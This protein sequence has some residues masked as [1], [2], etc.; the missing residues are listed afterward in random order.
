MEVTM[1]FTCDQKLLSEAITSVSRAV[2]AK[3]TIPALGG[4]K[5]SVSGDTLTLTGYNLEIGI[6]TSLSVTSEGE[7]QFIAGA[8]F[9]SEFTRKMPSETVTVETE[10]DS[11]IN[12]TGGIVECSFAGMPAEEFP[13]IPEVDSESV[14]EVRADVL[15]SMINMTSYAAANSDSKPI[16]T[17]QLFDV[18][19]GEF[20][21][22][23]IDGYRLA[24]RREKTDTQEKFYFV[25]PKRILQDISSLIREDDDSI[26]RISSDGRHA[27]FRMENM[28]VTARLLEGTFHNYRLSIP[29]S[30]KTEAV[31]SKRE[32]I[33]TLDRCCLI[34][35]DKNK[36]PVR[37]ES[38]EGCLKITCK[39]ALGKLSDSVE[40]EISGESIAIGF[41]CRMMLDALKSASGESVRLRFSGPMKVIEITSPEDDGYIF[42]VMPI[43]LR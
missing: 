42:L 11:V 18:C 14:L 2:S 32:L 28:T 43:Q 24:I 6:T 10:G 41:N 27:V 13:D 16:M 20:S 31:V 38:A 30:C 7:G 34:T 17:G 33:A 8:R 26:C 23:A 22:V 36:S 9:F 15:R 4:I 25:V 21:V 12:M 19:D 5:A 39:T 37:C 40:A 35:D 1:K 29:T 3:S